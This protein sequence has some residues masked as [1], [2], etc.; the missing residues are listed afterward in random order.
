MNIRY[1]FHRSWEKVAEILGI[2]L[3]AASLAG[4][5]TGVAKLKPVPITLVI[6]AE[7]EAPNWTVR[8]FVV[9]LESGTI[10]DESDPRVRTKAEDV[11]RNGPGLGGKEFL[12][13]REG[14]TYASR[15]KAQWN[16]WIKTHHAN[17]LVVVAD[18][19]N[20]G[21]NVQRWVVVPL[22]KNRYSTERRTVV[23]IGQTRVERQK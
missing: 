22:D 19:P 17:H 20:I 23:M 5:A 11:L 16:D 4:C 21:G 6:K 2:V 8:V 14:K 7:G 18:L 13:T 3:V 12:L 9:P 1:E 15:D 10:V